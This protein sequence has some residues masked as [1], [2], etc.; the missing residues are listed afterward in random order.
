MLD[1]IIHVSKAKDVFEP[2][3]GAD[4]KSSVAVS[5]FAEYQIQAVLLDKDG[6]LLDFLS[7][8]GKWSEALLSHFRQGL[9]KCQL[10]LPQEQI[11]HIWGTVHDEEGRITDYDT[12]GPLAMGTMDD[13]YAVLSWHGY[14]AGLSWGDA[15]RLVRQCAQAADEQLEQWRPA[16]AL[17]GVREFVTQ[18]ALNHIRL[19]VVTADDTSNALKHLDWLG[20][21]QHME[22]IIGSDQVERGKPFP[23]MVELACQ[24][25]GVDPSH[26][27]VIGDTNGDMDMGISAGCPLVIGIGTAEQLP[28]AHYTVPSFVPLI[29]LPGG[30]A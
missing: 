15:S 16:R 24:K 21:K 3:H 8:W 1:N 25:L 9:E 19:A 30:G 13:V 27:A 5:L 6:T 17:P 28:L 12:A 29:A 23:D 2:K 22:V 7:M 10:Y 18:C 4:Q 26:A 20:L 14:R 11:P